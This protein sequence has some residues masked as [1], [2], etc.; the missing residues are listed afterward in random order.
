[1]TEAPD[2]FGTGSPTWR[3][4]RKRRFGLFFS[5][6]FI[7]ATGTWLQN[8]AQAV[9]IF[10]LT[11]STFY[12]ALVNAA[13]FL[14]PVILAPWAG[15]AADRYDR[16]RI[17][18]VAQGSSAMF[19]AILAVL[20]LLGQVTVPILVG[21]AL[22]IGLGHALSVPATQA[23]LPSLVDE[24]DIAVGI[25]LNASTFNLARAV[26]PFAGAF[27]VAGL[28][29]TWAFTLN[30]VS[31]LAVVVALLVVKPR[32]QNFARSGRA[33]LSDSLRVVRSDSTLVFMLVVVAVV[34]MAADPVN[35]LTPVF[36]T[37]VF[38]RPDSF[39]GILVSGFGLGAVIGVSFVAH[40][41]TA[42]IRI[43][44]LAL[45]LLG[46][47]IA[48]FG[49]S[50][51]AEV[52]L[53]SLVVAG[54]GYLTAVTLATTMIHASIVEE[55]RGRV[56][57]IWSMSFFGIRPLASL[58]DGSIES[59]AGPRTAALCMAVPALLLAGWALRR[60]AVLKS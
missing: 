17:L 47:G 11:G 59:L 37:E 24:E 20:S 46:A 52:G 13:Q 12:V 25:A 43:V 44:A 50:S 48:C 22:G 36:S 41:F 29:F 40:R 38:A 16:R 26:G 23:L 51:T 31:F 14:G 3:V 4:L 1:M 42:S 39:T 49:L 21:C 19:A 45:G 54:V 58:I 10:R 35:T 53:A 57:A 7:S 18:F 33:R 9:L 8:I 60:A 5:G 2:R 56:M 55:H 32:P 6:N 27:V 34:S 28:G 15:S 30:S